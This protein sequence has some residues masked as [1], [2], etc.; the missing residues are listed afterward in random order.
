M[1]IDIGALLSRG[2]PEE[3][4]LEKIADGVLALPRAMWQG[5]KVTIEQNQQTATVKDVGNLTEAMYWPK[6]GKPEKIGKTVV[7]GILSLVAAPIL[8]LGLALK[9]IALAADP[10]ARAYSIIVQ[11]NLDIDALKKKKKTLEE[12]IEESRNNFVLCTN[13]IK[14]Q[15]QQTLIPEFINQ[16]N[17]KNGPF[18]KHLEA[19]QSRYSAETPLSRYD[20]SS[21]AILLKMLD[22]ESSHT[23]GASHHTELLSLVRQRFA[24]AEKLAE[25]ARDLDTLSNTGTQQ[26]IETAWKAVYPQD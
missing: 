21:D 7:Y 4:M 9:G 19:I 6:S 17:E 15:T 14:R 18:L 20:R 8:L 24:L 12:Q 5:R 26:K 2:R 25:V 1:G 10:K 16:L 22:P 3:T 11:N 13:D 23:Q